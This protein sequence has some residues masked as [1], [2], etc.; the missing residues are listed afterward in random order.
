M[1][2]GVAQAAE[3]AV[4]CGRL[5]ALAFPDDFSGGIVFADGLVLRHKVVAVGEFAGHAA[6]HVVVG[7][8]AAQ[9]NL[10][11]DRTIAGN[12]EETRLVAGFRQHDITVIQLDGRIHFRLRALV[13]PDD[14]LVSGHLDDGA[15]GVGLVLGEREQQVAV[16]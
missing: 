5:R 10:D 3:G 11:L 13:F 8:L 7:D 14:L 6:L 12:L 1:A 15:P 4:V 16:R 2:G 9:W